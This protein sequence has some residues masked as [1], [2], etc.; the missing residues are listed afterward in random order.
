MSFRIIYMYINS[1]K[2]KYNSLK[3]KICMRK[4]LHESTYIWPCNMHYQVKA[5]LS[6][7][8]YFIPYEGQDHMVNF[9][10]F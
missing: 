8:F 9:Q 3:L 5:I 2:L 1:L 7:D 6:D 4:L 10:T